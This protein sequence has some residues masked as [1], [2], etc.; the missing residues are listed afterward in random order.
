[1]VVKENILSFKKTYI[2][3]EEIKDLFDL[4]EH[5]DVLGVINLAK[6]E[7]VLEEVKSSKL[8]FKV[9]QVHLKYRIVRP[10]EDLSEYAREINSVFYFKFNSAYYKNNIKEYI[11]AMDIIRK[12]SVYF[13][14][15]NENL[16]FPL[17]VNERSFE[18]FANEKT[19]GKKDTLNVLANLGLSY[20]DLNVYKTPEPF[21]YAV[22]KSSQSKKVL[23]LENKDTWYTVKNL[24]RENKTILGID[25]KA[26]IYG[27]GMKIVSSFE[28]VKYNEEFSSNAS[29]LEFEYFGDIDKDGLKIYFLLANLYKE[30]NIKPCKEGYI[31]LINKRHLRRKKTGS[32]RNLR[33]VKLDIRGVENDFGFL[34]KEELGELWRMLQEN[35]ILPQEILNNRELRM[36]CNG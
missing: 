1:M 36:M 12:L 26:V 28:D 27:E 7:G 23:I 29:S 10:V 20:E 13:K 21:F 4:S 18:I 16:S 19:L 5:K 14:T 25:F 2:S 3:Y 33:K 34:G 31:F 35:Y 17:S 15:K 30:Y 22:N 6:E 24:I 9:P 8:T 11:R 32:E